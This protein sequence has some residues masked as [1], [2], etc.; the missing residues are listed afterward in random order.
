MNNKLQND[1]FRQL[2]NILEL[3]ECTPHLGLCRQICMGQCSVRQSAKRLNKSVS[4]RCGNRAEIRQ[5]KHRDGCIGSSSF[6]LGM[7]PILTL[8]PNLVR[9]RFGGGI[10]NLNIHEMGNGRTKTSPVSTLPFHRDIHSY[11]SPL[12]TSTELS[13]SN[14]LHPILIPPKT[15]PRHHASIKVDSHDSSYLLP[16]H[17]YVQIHPHQTFLAP[18]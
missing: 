11:F 15:Q 3:I 7:H 9:A 16:R 2:W 18:T 13:S 1:I 17:R 10:K 14:P 8:N 4:E 5:S 6:E 12:D